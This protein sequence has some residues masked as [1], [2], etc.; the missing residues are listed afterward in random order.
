MTK[1]LLHKVAILQNFKA[2]D[3]WL[4]RWKKNKCWFAEEQMIA[5]SNARRLWW[6]NRCLQG[7]TVS[8]YN[9]KPGHPIQYLVTWIKPYVDLTWQM[10]IPTIW[11]MRNKSGK[12]HWWCQKRLH[13]SST[14]VPLLQAKKFKKKPAF[15]VLKERNGQI[16]PR[17]FAN[18]RIPW[19]VK[20]VASSNGWMNG[21]LMSRWIQ[22]VC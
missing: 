15:A 21:A 18:L 16:P 1:I 17:V 3:G 22:W 4:R 13:G 10:H 8:P 11:G 14:Y 9:Y 5:K 19:N 6:A 7:S 2:S 12:Y 20:V